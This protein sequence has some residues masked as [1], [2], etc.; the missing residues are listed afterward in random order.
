VGVASVA[1]AFGIASP[2]SHVQQV[3]MPTAS[4]GHPQLGPGGPA[5]GNGRGTIVQGTVASKTNTTI[6]VT[7]TAGKTVTVNVS[8]T[9]RYVVQ[10]VASPTLADVA[11]GNGIAAVGT[12][13]PDGSLN[14]TAVQ[15]AAGGVPGL[16]G[17]GRRGGGGFGPGRGERGG[18]GAPSP[19]PSAAPSGSNT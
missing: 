14:A 5:P 19:Q 6:V 2:G 11:V 8:A 12:L 1:F 9:T 18:F 7:T 17:P 16:G 3:A 15:A 10:G 13:N 4:P